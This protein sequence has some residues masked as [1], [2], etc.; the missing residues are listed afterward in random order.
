MVE[1]R[2]N[3]CCDRALSKAR[4]SD[5]TPTLEDLAWLFGISKRW[6]TELR[7]RG[8]LPEGEPLPKLVKRMGRYRPEAKNAARVA[9]LARLRGAAK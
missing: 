7:K 3:R 5:H 4:L 6:A 1:T 8:V 9:R 2:R